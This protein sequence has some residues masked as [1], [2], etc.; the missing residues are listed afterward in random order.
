MSSKAK[1][2]DQWKEIEALPYQ[3]TS[4][5]KKEETVEVE[6]GEIPAGVVESKLA[7]QESRAAVQVADVLTDSMRKQ[8]DSGAITLPCE[9][10]C[11]CL[12]C[13]TLNI[14]RRQSNSK[15]YIT[16]VSSS[17]LDLHGNKMTSK[18]AGDINS[19]D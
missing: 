14:K 7:E 13:N 18:V 19:V 16:M 4:I 5:L 12:R 3:P 10:L 8:P 2:E 17:C 9:D 15:R 6:E 1:F 11:I